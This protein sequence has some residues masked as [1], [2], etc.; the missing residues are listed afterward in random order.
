MRKLFFH[1]AASLLVGTV[2]TLAQAPAGPPQAPAPAGLRVPLP[3]VP[4]LSR[5]TW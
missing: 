3:P 2:V 5:Q 1:I 4:M